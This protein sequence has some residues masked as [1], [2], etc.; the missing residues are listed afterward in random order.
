M[1]KRGWTWVHVLRPKPFDWLVVTVTLLIIAFIVLSGTEVG[2]S[3]HYTCALCRA[4]RTYRITFGRVSEQI[5]ENSCSNWY[6]AH[7]EEHHEHLWVYS[8][9]SIG[10][11]IFGQAISVSDR[12]R[13][14]LW[15][16]S[17]EAQMEIYSHF[18][19]VQFARNL[20]SILANKRKSHSLRRKRP[21]VLC[22]H[23][24]VRAF[25]I[26]GSNGLIHFAANRHK[27]RTKKTQ[28]CVTQL[29]A[30]CGLNESQDAPFY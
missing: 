1:S 21:S 24:G 16:I 8:G 29:P 2:K 5:E 6:A 30:S 28:R 18:K 25:R 12:T 3:S 11:N 4:S 10:F 20:F 19:N 14:P 7:V 15:R 9:S 22:C 13:N 23:G 27:R 17:P 26:H